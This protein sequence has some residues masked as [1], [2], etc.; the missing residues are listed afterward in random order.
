MFDRLSPEARA[1]SWKAALTYLDTARDNDFAG[2]F[3][4]SNALDMVQTYTTDCVALKKAIDD[5][6]SRATANYSK[7]ADWPFQG[8]PDRSP[9]TSMTASA[10]DADPVGGATP[11]NP[12]GVLPGAPA[13]GPGNPADAQ[14]GSD[15]VLE[16]VVNRTE[17]TYE[18]MMREEQGYATTNGLLALIDAMSLLPG[19]KT[20]VFFAEGLAIPPA[21][22]ARF[23]SVV[24]TANRAN[25]S[26][27]TV[28]S[29]GLRVHSSQSETA[30]N[31]N[32]IGN[33]SFDRNLDAPGARPLT[34]GLET[35]EDNLRKDPSVSLKLLADRTGGFLINNTNNLTKGFQLIDS[36][37]RFH[38]LL[39]YAPKNANFN[40][41]WRRIA[42]TV[43][44]RDVQVRNRTGYLAVRSRARCRCSRTKA[45]RSPRSSGSRC[46]PTSRARGRVRVP[47]AKH[48]GRVALLV[49]TDAASLTFQPDAQAQTWRT[50]FTLLARIRNAQG[51]VVRKVSQPVPAD[52]PRRA[53][54]VS[55]GRL[56]F[57]REP[58]LPPGPTRSTTP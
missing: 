45:P 28:D 3:V 33:T 25:V 27:Y 32:A 2:V 6:T 48:P 22:L 12:G 41:E 29:A 49:A 42:V 34:E 31:V 18:T 7:N 17:A 44:R 19:R 54:D 21:V 56:L 51:D 35:N 9:S 47:D 10:E 5:A 37:R 15:A 16:R 24:A 23:D 52:R 46:R 26:V 4:V 20:V 55:S 43:S 13:A 14:L 11:T 36:D 30:A 57:F 38:Y 50:D 8:R 58:D 53:V 39:T 40:G 1:L